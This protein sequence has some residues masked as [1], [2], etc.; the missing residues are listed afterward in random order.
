MTTHAEPLNFVLTSSDAV[1]SGLE[2]PPAQREFGSKPDLT[3]EDQIF[4]RLGSRPLS[5]DLVSLY[6]RTHRELPPALDVLRGGYDIWLVSNTVSVMKEPG[7]R[8]VRRLGLEVRYGDDAGISIADVF[9]RTSFLNIVRGKGQTQLTATIDFGGHLAAADVAP[10]DLR[11]LTADARFAIS[12]KADV[13]ATLSLS[14]VTPL[15]EAVG[16]GD[17]FAQ[18]VLTRH[19]LPLLG[20]HSFFQVLLVSPQTRHLSF[21]ARISATVTL[22]GLLESPRRTKWIPLECDLVSGD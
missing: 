1:D 5:W 7:K 20:D 15:V 16:N 22:Y 13:L 4:I 14:I 19:D 17:S 3:V 21:E 6:Q 9:P 10:A 11:P 2:I 12:A 8:N 18:W